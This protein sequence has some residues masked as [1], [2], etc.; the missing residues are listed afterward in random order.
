MTTGL[1]EVITDHGDVGNR[2]EA[3]CIEVPD[4]TDPSGKASKEKEE[5][6]TLKK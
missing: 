4:E 1:T 2:K 3:H 5:A 6:A